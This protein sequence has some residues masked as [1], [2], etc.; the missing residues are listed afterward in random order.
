MIKELFKYYRKY[1]FHK[2]YFKPEF[3]KYD[4]VGITTLFTFYWD[5][6]IDTI[7][8]AKK[9]C[10][11]PDGVMV[12]GVM[13][14]ILPER[15]EKVTGIRPHVGTLHI[16]GELDKNNNLII[17]SLPLDYSIL[18]EID[19]K[20]PASD[21]YFAY[22]TRGCINK[23]AFCAVP[24]LEP[25]YQDFL[26]VSEQVKLAENKYGQK[27]NLLLL[28]NNVL[29][30]HRYN[31]IID[32]IKAAGFYKAAT[33]VVPNQY[34][35]AIKNLHEG[36]NDAGYIKS[37]V[38]QFKMLLKKE[39]SKQKAQKLYDLLRDFHLL[40]E[41]TATK[42]NIFQTYN[43]F[44]PYF[45]KMYKNIQEHRFLRYTYCSKKCLKRRDPF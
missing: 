25:N 7:N 23:C 33:Y 9:L 37:C 36:Q 22:M 2:Y 42:K 12:G 5:I 40:D 20:Y 14:S 32:D 30:S 31:E 8:F 15:V 44:K 35:S 28:D 34:E 13:A 43:L 6:T 21:A 38:K 10:K 11:S 27:R 45:E 4:I 18:E 17:D 1:F 39:K 29:A 19:Y 3:R 41:Y 16:P 26:P 24:K